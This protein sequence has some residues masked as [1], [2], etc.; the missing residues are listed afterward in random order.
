MIRALA[1]TLPIV[2][3]FPP[4]LP[5]PTAKWQWHGGD[6]A[7]YTHAR[8]NESIDAVYWS[9]LLLDSWHS[10]TE[11][12]AGLP[13]FPSFP[14]LALA[15]LYPPSLAPP[16][17]FWLSALTNMIPFRFPFWAGPTIPMPPPTTASEVLPAP[18]HP[19]PAGY[20][21]GL[22]PIPTPP[23]TRNLVTDFGAI[24]DG[25]TDATS[26][27]QRALSSM[28]SGVLYVPPGT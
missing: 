20:R 27:L 1:H 18:I 2:S 23:A 6:A 22:A 7:N 15:F 28:T 21:S 16:C 25:K 26:A 24:G 14:S 10:A 8:Q 5:R 12:C 19:Y 11:S 13:I 9:L 4:W 17:R 3:P